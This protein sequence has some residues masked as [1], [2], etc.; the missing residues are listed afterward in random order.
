MEDKVFSSQLASVMENCQKPLRD[1]LEGADAASL[2][3]WI[4]ADLSACNIPTI[5]KKIE[6]RIV[7]YNTA[8]RKIFIED[9]K[10]VVLND[11]AGIINTIKFQ[12]K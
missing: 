5:K 9:M 11:A 12:K 3:G 8:E 4:L 10:S 7:K 1:L 2:D 6:G